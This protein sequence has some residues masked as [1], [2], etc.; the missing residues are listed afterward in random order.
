MLED[1][2]RD[3]IANPDCTRA[4][5]DKTRFINQTM[6]HSLQL[7]RIFPCLMQRPFLII[8]R[9]LKSVVIC[10]YNVHSRLFSLFTCSFFHTLCFS[11]FDVVEYLHEAFCSTTINPASINAYISA[12][13][14]VQNLPCI[15]VGLLCQ[16]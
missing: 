4:L 1:C 2:R 8:F 7:F 9:A 10:F 12:C 11:F 6:F 13:T 14:T 15:F 16:C 3:F 5:Q